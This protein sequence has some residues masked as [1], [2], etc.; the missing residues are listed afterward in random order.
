M[1]TLS[2]SRMVLNGD[3]D[4]GRGQLGMG[5]A[6]TA[7]TGALWSLRSG[8]NHYSIASA[9]AIIITL[10][11]VGTGSTQAQ[12]GYWVTI[13]N[14]NVTDTITVNNFAG[15]TINT[16]TGGNS[17]MYIAVDTAFAASNWVIQYDTSGYSSVT[18]LQQAYNASG[19]S[20]VT[21]QIVLNAL[22]TLKIQDNATPIALPL[23]TV[24]DNAG[25]NIFRISNSTNTNNAAFFG[26]TS[27]GLRSLAVGT[28]TASAA[29]TVVFGTGTA[30][31]A[32]AF[33]LGTSTASGAGSTILSDASFT[34]TY[35][36]VGVFYQLYAGGSWIYGG[37]VQ[38]GT[39]KTSPNRR[40]LFFSGTTA[41]TTGLVLISG[42]VTTASST[43]Y[44]ITVTAY[45]RDANVASAVSATHVINALVTNLSGT[46]T[47]VSQQLT[48]IE[49]AGYTTTPSNAVLSAATNVVSLTLTAPDNINGGFT[50][51]TMDYRVI[52]EYSA[53]TE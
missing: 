12:P 27:T 15:T 38:E 33:V 23:F 7:V 37:A 51:G 13:I 2:N 40:T 25:A 47:I 30:S 34:G 49:T 35:T 20:T 1:T 39:T 41:I 17:A 48:T 42:I 21:P 50:T 3:I 46:A 24:S 19:I 10:P 11:D 8:G 31:A 52:V 6:G 45:G 5:W 32:N 18:N 53:L 16:L 9:S 29:N 26:G 44:R 14:T 4:T 28:G 22:S 36:G 43:T